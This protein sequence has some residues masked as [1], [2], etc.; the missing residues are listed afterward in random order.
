MA[1]KY[2]GVDLSRWNGA[3]D[4]K[5][6]KNAHILGK[7]VK[8]VMLRLGYGRSLDDRFAQYYAAAKAA[9][10]YVGVYLYSLASNAAEARNEA[11]W[12]L[13]QLKGLEIDYPVAFDFED[14]VVLGKGFTRAQ[15]TAICRAFLERVRTGG[16]YPVLYTGP[17]VIKAH[18]DLDRLKDYDLWL[19][20]YTKEGSEYQYG[21]EM[22]Q[23]SVAGGV[24]D[25]NKVG[26]VAGVPGECDCN[27]SYVGYAAKI[28][29][30]GLNGKKPKK[31]RITAVKEVPAAERSD[32]LKRLTKLGYTVTAE[33]E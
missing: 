19:A 3:V 23:F 21:Q 11:A 18:L 2:A 26:R 24:N 8:F 20:Q 6:L 14:S 28:E 30:L 25:Y 10:L 1:L 22:W 13:E 16:Y 32:E 29:R 7:P 17:A 33:T 9:G 4:F 27:W 31:Y 5:A 15:Y 12:T